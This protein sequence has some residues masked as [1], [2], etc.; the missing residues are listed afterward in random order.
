MELDQIFKFG[1]PEHVVVRME[2]D[3]FLTRSTVME[4]FQISIKT[5]KKDKQCAYKSKFEVRSPYRCCC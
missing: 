3:Q 2:L 1:S 4:S 5:I